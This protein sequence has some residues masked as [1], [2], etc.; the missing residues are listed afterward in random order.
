MVSQFMMKIEFSTLSS[1]GNVANSFLLCG[2]WT[3]PDALS[4]VSDEEELTEG[5][6]S[7]LSG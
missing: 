4:I 1:L 3:P 5:L 6:G 2:N 7:L